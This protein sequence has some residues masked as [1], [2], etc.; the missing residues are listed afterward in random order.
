MD[1]IKAVVGAAC[2]VGV[3]IAAADAVKPSERFNT[4]IKFIFSLIFLLA[5]LTP[6]LSGRVD[7]SV[8]EVDVNGYVRKQAAFDAGVDAML[9][10]Q[11]ERGIEKELAAKLKE[12]E[13]ICSYIRIIVNIEE[14]N[15]ISITNAELRTSNNAEG[16]RIAAEALGI[17]EEKIAAVTDG[18]E[19]ME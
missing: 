18:R 16:I 13:I 12:H 1:V 6:I 8:S 19:G 4:Q 10:R 7:F 17:S 3:A 15:S 9:K 5:A 14:D 11:I 2:F